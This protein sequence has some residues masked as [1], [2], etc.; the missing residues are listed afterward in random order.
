ML[1]ILIDKFIKSRNFNK[2]RNR[3]KLI[4][5][6]GIMGLFINMLLFSMKILIG[7]FSNSISIISD[8]L[9]NLSDCL[10]SVVTIYGS[11]L[12]EKP[13]DENHPFGHGR[14][15]Y[16]ATFMVGLFITLVGFQLLKSSIEGIISP[17][18]ITSSW[19]STIILVFS[20]LLKLYMYSYNTKTAKIAD[21]VLNKGVATDS[22]NDVMATSLVL[23]SVL[24]FRYLKVNIDGYV[25]LMISILVIKSGIEIFLE[26]G[27]VLIGR[28]ISED[29]LKKL[30]KIVLQGKYVK[31]VHNIQVHEY[32][33]GQLSGSCHVEVPANID[34]Y[35]MHKIINDIEQQVQEETDI[36]LNIH[37]DPSYLLDKDHFKKVKDE[38]AFDEIDLE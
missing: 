12:S 22:L 13:A 7:L 34:V 2:K 27:N 24:V 29:K 19:I 20:I 14:S 37:M 9:N 6:T 23:L 32:G 18:V 10:T 16:I 17:N 35:S 3:D 11:K 8:S 33:K 26:M 15:E 1:D 5:L 21:S 38:S 30:E 25:G 4:R 36:Y 31:G 28:Q